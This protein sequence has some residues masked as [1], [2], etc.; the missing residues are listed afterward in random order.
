MTESGNDYKIKISSVANSSVFDFSDENFSL[1]NKSQLKDAIS[2]NGGEQMYKPLPRN[3]QSHGKM[4]SSGP[5]KIEASARE[6]HFTF[7]DCT[8]L[9]RAMA[10]TRQSM[11]PNQVLIIK[12]K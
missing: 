10:T 7:H 3:R 8:I 4:I 12:L 1:L 11:L 9:H 5:V 6:E 2:P